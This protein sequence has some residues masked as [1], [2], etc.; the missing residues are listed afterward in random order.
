M[1][2]TVNLEYIGEIS[3]IRYGLKNYDDKVKC[4]CETE[5]ES[6]KRIKKHLI[7]VLKEYNTQ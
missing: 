2:R 7:V 5:D 3:N 6:Y 1:Y 4:K